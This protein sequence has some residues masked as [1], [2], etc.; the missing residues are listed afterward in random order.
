MGTAGVTFTGM[1]RLL[2]AIEILRSRRV[3]PKP[4]IDGLLLVGYHLFQAGDLLGIAN[5]FDPDDQNAKAKGKLWLVLGVLAGLVALL[6]WGPLAIRLGAALILGSPIWCYAMTYFPER[7][8]GGRSYGT[9]A[10][11]GLWVGWAFQY[12]PWPVLALLV[13]WGV[14]TGKRA[15]ACRSYRTFWELA[16]WDSPAKTRSQL[17]YAAGID[18]TDPDVA[19]QL[20]KVLIDNDDGYQKDLAYS[21]LTRLAFAQGDYTGAEQWA[22]EGLERNP[23]EPECRQVRAVVRMHQDRFE[24]AYEDCMIAL[25]APHCANADTVA[26]CAAICVHHIG[27]RDTEFLNLMGQLIQLHGPQKVAEMVQEEHHVWNSPVWQGFMKL[28]EA[29]NKQMV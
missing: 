11:V 23:R 25:S 17:N 5:P 16:L 22:T 27:G 13:L 9:L 7:T 18:K 6:F 24:E 8:L 26:A 2:N 10:G 20:L 3:W 14:R 29:A 19:L 12:A 15:W 28:S 1:D 4:S 21:N